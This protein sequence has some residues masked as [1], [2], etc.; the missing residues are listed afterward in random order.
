MALRGTAPDQGGLLSATRRRREETSAQG[1]CR[2][3]RPGI[4]LLGAEASDA[5]R[6]T[7]RETREPEREGQ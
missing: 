5:V 7:N 4:A 6:L 1:S 2:Y 3:G